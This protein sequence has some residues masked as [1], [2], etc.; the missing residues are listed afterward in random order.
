MAE[1][2]SISLLSRPQ[3]LCQIVQRDL[4][5]EK[6]DHVGIDPSTGGKCPWPSVRASVAPQSLAKKEKH[7]S[8][9]YP[10]SISDHAH[11]A[12]I[13]QNLPELM[14]WTSG[15]S[16]YRQIT[17][18]SNVERGC[19]LDGY[20]ENTTTVPPS[21]RGVL[22][23]NCSL[24]GVFIARLLYQAK[25]VR[26]RAAVRTGIVTSIGYVLLALLHL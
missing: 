14:A 6:L 5:S 21:L 10:K 16:G 3:I 13:L 1:E 8:R 23:A 11:P 20:A 17:E 19:S 9:W 2:R 7:P 26:L 18:S 22:H 15:Y 4:N 24:Q 12:G 25:L